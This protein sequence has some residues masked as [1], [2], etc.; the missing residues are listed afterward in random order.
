[1]DGLEIHFMVQ[2]AGLTDELGKRESEEFLELL[3]GWRNELVSLLFFRAVPPNCCHVLAHA[4]NSLRR[5]R[6]R[7]DRP[8]G[9]TEPCSS[10]LATQPLV[11]ADPSGSSAW[12]RTF[13][14]SPVGAAKGVRREGQ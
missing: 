3:L 11:A 12:R 1:M 9:H 6:G 14:W 4:E 10:R 8:T 7:R 2:R 13:I 5:A